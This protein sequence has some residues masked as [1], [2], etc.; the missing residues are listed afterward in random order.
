MK[1]ET[2]GVIGD[3][4]ILPSNFRQMR[5][6]RDN[7]AYGL[8]VTVTPYEN[9]LKLANECAAGITA[10]DGSGFSRLLYHLVLKVLVDDF[11]PRH[12]DAK[13]DDSLSS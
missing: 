7:M 5:Y 10:K 12:K 1:D 3:N 4:A 8:A 13:N 6:D 11:L 2:A 9:L